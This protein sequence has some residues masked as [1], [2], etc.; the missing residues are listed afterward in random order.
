MWRKSVAVLAVV[1]LAPTACQVSEDSRTSPPQG[2]ETCGG[3]CDTWDIYNDPGRFQYDFTY[4]LD[5]LPREGRAAKAPWPGNWWPFNQ[6]GIARRWK[7][8]DEPSPALKYDLAFAP[9]QVHTVTHNGHQVQ[10]GPAS[11][12]ELRNHGTWVEPHQ[13]WEGHCNGWSAAA[14]SEPEPRHAVEYNGVTFE[15]SDIKALLTELYWQA[16]RAYVGVPC[17][18]RDV[19]HDGALSG[20]D[21]ESACRDTNAGAFHVTVTNMLGIYHHAFA[22]DKV[23]STQIWN[24]PVLAYRVTQQ[25]EVDVAEAL[26]LLGL[27]ESDEYT[28][29]PDAAK[30]VSV[31]MELDYVTDAVP[32][33]TE[34][35][36]PELDEHTR[37]VSYRYILELDEEGKVVGG[38]WVGTS[39]TEHPD[40]LWTVSGPG[41]GVDQY[42]YDNPYIRYDKVKMLLQKSLEE[43]PNV[44][45]ASREPNLAI[46]DVDQEGASDS[47][48]FD[49]RGTVASVTVE[50]NITHPYVGDL[51]VTLEHEGV[52]ATLYNRE[53]GSSDDIHASFQT[54]VF[55]GM[56]PSGEWVLR[57]QDVAYRDTGTLESWSLHVTLT[58]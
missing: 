5:E 8:P 32:P 39:K 15:V 29:N 42:D 17:H 48:V 31:S 10:V 57:V 54:Q 18:G 2:K 30:L 44:L 16:L 3:K 22:M 6:Q 19:A 24:Y 7:D 49:E 20:P 34:P 52:R 28:P 36:L 9:N 12:W 58:D 26:R 35:Y 11:L 23:A 40:F 41:L 37:T 56:D 38:E 13:G 43:Q 25:R 45:E 14:I 47:I 51:V 46:P 55:S 33:S 1:L 27:P 4:V 50:V 21:P 53:G